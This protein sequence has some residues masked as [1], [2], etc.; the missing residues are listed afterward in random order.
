MPVVSVATAGKI[1][2]TKGKEGKGVRGE[3]GSVPF[4]VKV[5][6]KMPPAWGLRLRVV[7]ATDPDVQ[8]SRIRFLGRTRFQG[9][10]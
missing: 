8:F 3:K 4:I 1:I 2:A 9:L 10:R 5:D 6:E 7:P